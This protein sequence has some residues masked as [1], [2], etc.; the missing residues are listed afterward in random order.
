MRVCDLRSGHMCDPASAVC[1]T[2]HTLYECV[3][4]ANGHIQRMALMR[5]A[6]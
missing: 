2:P 3:N 4:L 6:L 5:M 1:A